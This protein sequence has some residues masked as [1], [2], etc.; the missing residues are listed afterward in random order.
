[1]KNRDVD[2]V[3]RSKA[4]QGR[5]SKPDRRCSSDVFTFADKSSEVKHALTPIDDVPNPQTRSPQLPIP[6]P[7]YPVQSRSAPEPNKPPVN[8]NYLT[9]PQSA[10]HNGLSKTD[11]RTHSIDSL[12]ENVNRDSVKSNGQLTNFNVSE[13]N[14]KVNAKPNPINSRKCARTSPNKC[15]RSRKST[16][17]TESSFTVLNVPTFH[18]PPPPKLRK[19]SKIDMAAIRQKMRRERRAPRPTGGRRRS[20]GGGASTDFGVTVIGYSDSSSSDGT[21]SS[22]ESETED[23]EPDLW[24]RS[25]PPCK[26][27]FSPD[28]VDFLS[29]FELTTHNF[30][31]CKFVSRV[32]VMVQKIKTL[33]LG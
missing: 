13:C 15:K 7:N 11:S 28:K 10:S 6:S 27:D 24:I 5:D 12:G 31:N 18:G 32:S 17:S 29:M 16:V 4:P 14:F 3:D 2:F 9:A 22:S 26:P 33:T 8:N 19:L 30:K 25:G 23:E 21:C 20:P 1:M